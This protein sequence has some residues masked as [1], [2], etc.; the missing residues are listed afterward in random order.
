MKDYA[1][2]FVRY[3]RAT[4]LVTFQKR[5]LRLIISPQ[6]TEEVDYI[7][8]E[9]SKRYTVFYFILSWFLQFEVMFPRKGSPLS[10]IYQK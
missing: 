1:D 5:T 2:A 8:K 7:L 10:Q 4:E 3:I 9:T 6:K